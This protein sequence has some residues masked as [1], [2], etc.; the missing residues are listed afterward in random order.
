MKRIDVVGFGPGSID[1]MTI[2]AR[3]SI[4]E[5]DVVVGFS[6]YIDILK[7]YFPS[8]EYVSTGM[9]S[10]VERVRKAL[11]ISNDNKYVCL[12]CSG[13]SQIYGMAGLCYELAE[14]YKEVTINTIPGIT[15]AISGSALLGAAI[16]NDLATISLSDYHT[17][18]EMIEKRLYSCA[19]CDFVIALYN[20]RSKRRP[21]GLKRA[22]D[23]L[24][25]VLDRNRICAVAVNIGR[26]N[27][28]YKIM[29]L[30]EMRDYEA[31]M[32]TT[33]FIGNSAST[34]INGKMVTRRGYSLE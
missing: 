25:R 19:Q 32:F 33:V 6:T 5:C 11:D 27:E 1:K 18:W 3:R 26:S 17:S 13:D 14:D 4:D 22:C 20:P 28:F 2:E 31:D 24:L 9:G 10:E 8:K 12:V 30:E 29:T 7:E 23:V 34:N 21:N 16:G 15:A